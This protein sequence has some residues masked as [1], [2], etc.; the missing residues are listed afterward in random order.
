M[1][2]ILKIDFDQQ[3]VCGAPVCWLKYTTNKIGVTMNRS[4]ELESP[5][6]ENFFLV[7]FKKI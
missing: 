6:S 7:K 5:E 1:A 3:M 2:F 4:S